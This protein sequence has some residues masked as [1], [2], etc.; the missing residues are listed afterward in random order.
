MTPEIAPEVLDQKLI[1]S[2]IH[3]DL[4]DG[5]KQHVR[6]K[7]SKLLRHE[8]HIVRVRVTIEYHQTK[9]NHGQFTAKGQI[10]IQG[11]DIVAGESG[12]DAYVAIDKLVSE[13][14]RG[15]RKRS[16]NRMSKRDKPRGIDLDAELPKVD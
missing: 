4:T 8:P 1:I 16:T 5:M 12:D 7:V 13:L 11:P 2:G 10:E 6:E 15:L 9:S 14:D 3:I